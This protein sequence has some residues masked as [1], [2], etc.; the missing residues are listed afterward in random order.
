MDEILHI[1]Y[2]E[3]ITWNNAYVIN[4]NYSDSYGEH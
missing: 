4:V 3:Y 1:N 2:T